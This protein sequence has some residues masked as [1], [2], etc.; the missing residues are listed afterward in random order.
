MTFTQV[1]A[2]RVSASRV[3]TASESAMEASSESR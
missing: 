1:G 3:D 2:S